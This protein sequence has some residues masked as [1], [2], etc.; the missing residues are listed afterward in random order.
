[1]FAYAAKH[2]RVFGAYPPGRQPNRNPRIDS[3]DATA[4]GANLELGSSRVISGEAVTLYPNESPGA[5]EVYIAPTL[6]GGWTTLTETLTYQW[7]ATGG[8]FSD[9]VTGG[10]HDLLGN[11]SLLGTEWRAPRVNEPTPVQLWVVQRDERYGA[12][13]Y[14]ASVVVA[15]R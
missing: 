8:S 6:D 4:A 3:I 7:L 14:G 12:S 2:L 15:P 13:V 9:K 11:Q 5:R 10:G 1:V